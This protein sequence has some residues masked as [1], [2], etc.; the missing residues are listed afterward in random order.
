MKLLV[1]LS[2]MAAS[3]AGATDPVEGAPVATCTEYLVAD[4]E[5]TRRDLPEKARGTEYSELVTV[6]YDLDGSGSAV[7][8]RIAKNSERNVFDPITLELLSRAQFV[9]GIAAK[10]CLY[11][12]TYSAMR[13]R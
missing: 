5:M 2:L 8:A 6:R 4:G 7:N 9:P 1:A 11:V 12:R 13:R 3:A 10:D